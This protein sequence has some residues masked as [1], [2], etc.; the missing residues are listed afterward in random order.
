MGILQYTPNWLGIRTL[1]F[2]EV[3]RFLKVYNQTLVAPVVNSLLLLAVFSLALGERVNEIGGIPFVQFMAPGLIMMSMIQ[4]AFA[5]TSSAL[6]MGKVIGIII[7]YLMP[8]ITAGEMTFCMVMAGVTRGAIVGLMVGLSIIPFVDLGVHDVVM[9]IFYTF[10]A[11]LLVALLGLLA[12]IVAETFDQMSAVTTYVIT[13]LVFLSGTFYSVKSLPEIWYTISL[14]NPF[15]YMLDGFRYSMTGYHDG[16]LATG[17][18]FLT[19]CNVV[20]WVAAHMIVA[21]GYRLKT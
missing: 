11:T 4:H 2:K 14:Y 16:D 15:F 19:A 21:R 20:L 3:S 1:Y 5:N 7:D 9:L 18:V 12:G 6:I 13:P 10:S 17:M 8:P